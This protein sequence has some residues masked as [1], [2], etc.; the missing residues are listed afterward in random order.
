MDG[1]P[2]V[3]VEAVCVEALPSGSRVEMKLAATEQSG[4][5][6]EPVEERARMA[7]TSS[8]GSG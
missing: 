1:E 5:E 4:L 8:L 2:V 6:D 7:L 3:V